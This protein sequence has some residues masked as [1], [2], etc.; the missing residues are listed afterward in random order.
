[1]LTIRK[2]DDRGHA[3]F[4]WLDARHTFSFG[5]YHDPN[6]MG[7]GPLRVINDDRIAP[8]K[9][10]PMHPHANMEI[11]TYVLDGAL[12]HQDSLGNGSVIKPGDVQRM[13]AGTGIR[14]SEANPSATEAAHL[15][16]IWI[17]PV[18][19]GLPPGYEQKTFTI[20]DKRGKLRLVASPDGRDGSVTIRSAV[21]VYASVLPEKA[22]VTH[23][24]APGHSTW[25]QVARGR[26]TVNG[27]ALNAGDGAS[28]TDTGALSI[29]G[30][31]D[32]EVLLFDI[33][34]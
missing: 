8:G 6:H 17:E 33:A 4:G 2:A 22:S 29:E 3:N 13:S 10:F 28:T 18:E 31:E 20:E 16:Q 11:V 23:D 14:H 1:M 24:V 30:V 34:A 25:L 9:G 12:A 26:V 21:A 5:Q 7:F 32:A 27:T 15:L 19:T